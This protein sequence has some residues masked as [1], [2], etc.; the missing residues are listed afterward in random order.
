[1]QPTDVN[2]QATER[3]RERAHRDRHVARRKRSHYI[4][5]KGLVPLMGLFCS[6]ALNPQHDKRSIRERENFNNATYTKQDKHYSKVWA[7]KSHSTKKKKKLSW[8]NQEIQKTM[9]FCFNMPFAKRKLIGFLFSQQLIGNFYYSMSDKSFNPLS[10]NTG[11]F[12]QRTYRS[13]SC[14]SWIHNWITWRTTVAISVQ[15]KHKNMNTSSSLWNIK[16]VH[17]LSHH[18]KWNGSNHANER[19]IH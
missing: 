8:I 11:R 2:Q 12:L 9:W 17:K 5:V 10:E 13:S 14:V 3:E 18:R 6:D 4:S 15:E 19:V 1:M 16:I 7:S